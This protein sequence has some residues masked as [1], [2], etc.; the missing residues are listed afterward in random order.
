MPKLI[1]DIEETE[2]KEMVKSIFSK[3]DYPLRFDIIRIGTSYKTAFLGGDLD[4]EMKIMINPGN[5]IIK[6]K[7]LFRGHLARFIFFL[8]NKK[9]GLNREIGENLEVRDLAKFTQN[10]FADYKAVK[11]G[12]KKEMRDFY[13]E[14]I[15]KRIY[16]ERE[17]SKG[18]YIEFYASGLILKK[19][20]EEAEVENL[21]ENINIPRLEPLL[22]EL[23]RLNY[24]YFFGDS[25][26]KKAWL[27]TFYL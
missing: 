1:I 8:I 27:K 9:E 15:L 21:I 6:N 2:L 25:A 18:E 5:K 10:F 4:N 7:R 22:K 23:D 20:K 24:P 11:Y 12:F 26:L 19:V 17:I 16:D 3:I 14:K 13:V